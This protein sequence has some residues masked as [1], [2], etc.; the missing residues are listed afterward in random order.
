MYKSR[1]GCVYEEFP[2]EFSRIATTVISKPVSLKMLKNSNIQD[3]VNIMIIG[4]CASGK[5]AWVKNFTRT[6]KG[7]Y[8][9][10]KDRVVRTNV[11]KKLYTDNGRE[12]FALPFCILDVGSECT[13]KMVEEIMKSVSVHAVIFF[14][15][16]YSSWSL[17]GIEEVDKQLVCD[18]KYIKEMTAVTRNVRARVC[19]GSWLDMYR[20]D[21]E[22]TSQLLNKNVTAHSLIT[23]QKMKTIPISN[24]TGFNVFTLCSYV[25][26]L[27]YTKEMVIVEDRAHLTQDMFETLQFYVNV[28]QPKLPGEL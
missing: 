28:P 20:E 16:A 8:V 10:A 5:T 17:I 4:P 14:Y 21:R 7:G 3:S 24:K 6:S 23:K 9:S 2:E 26:Y 15:N 1:K 25:L 18:A 19:A 22:R 12:S 13:P 27:I 11:C